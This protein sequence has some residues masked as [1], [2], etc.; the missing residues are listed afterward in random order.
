MALFSIHTH[1]YTTRTLHYI[2]HTRHRRILPVTLFSLT[3]WRNSPEQF[4]S[5]SLFIVVC[6]PC[7]VSLPHHNTSRPLESRKVWPP[8][9]R[10]PVLVLSAGHCE[11]ADT[12]VPSVYR[13]ASLMLYYNARTFGSLQIGREGRWQCQWYWVPVGGWYA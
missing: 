6:R 7:T 5:T 4:S 8:G 2:L 10:S 12:A 1:L 13:C 11:A 3:E 9:T